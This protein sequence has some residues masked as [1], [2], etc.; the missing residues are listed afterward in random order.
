VYL[1]GCPS[2]GDNIPSCQY[3]DFITVYNGTDNTMLDVGLDS[4][5]GEC[6]CIIY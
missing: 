5:T 2:V 1:D 6:S 3:T 4:F